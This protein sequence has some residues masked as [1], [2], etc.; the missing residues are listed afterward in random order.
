MQSRPLTVFDLPML[1][2]A[3]D[4]NTW[5]PGQKAE[6]YLNSYCFST[7]YEDEQGPVGVLQYTKV[8]RLR[9]QWCDENDKTRNAESIFQAIED[10]VKMAKKAGYQEIVFQTDN[11]ALAA[12]C[13]K[14]GFEESRGEYRK[15]V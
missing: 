12:F 15:E 6:S 8:M 2:K 9:T 4:K 5:H 3:M 1:Q 10:S 14:L 13:K 7:V 11:P